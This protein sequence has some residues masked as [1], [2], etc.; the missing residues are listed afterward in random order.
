MRLWLTS[1]AAVLL[2]L[3]CGSPYAPLPPA[4]AAGT[5]TGTVTVAPC[6]PVEM[7]G[8]PPCPPRAGIRVHFDQAAT[9]RATALTDGSGTYVASLTPGTYQVW[10]E[11]GIARPAAVAVTVAAGQSVTLN[12]VVDSGIR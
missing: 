7:P 1:A 4:P 2:L 10:A 6:R 12:L 5:V 9:T 8:Q 3:G 11:G